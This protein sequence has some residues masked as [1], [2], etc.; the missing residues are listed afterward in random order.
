MLF[1]I[2]VGLMVILV[3]AFWVYQGL[4]SSAL[5]FFLTIL[6]SA[7][8]FAFYE[9]VSGLVAGFLDPS[10][11]LPLA[12]LVLF[13]VTLVL[14]RL[15]TDKFIPDNV[16]LP[17]VVDRAGAGL[18]GL[19]TGLMIVGT[20]LIGVQMFGIGSAVFGFERLEAGD[21]G[22][23]VR[24]GFLLGPDSFAAGMMQT[25]SGG[26]LG[27]GNP[28]GTAKPD[29]ILDLYAARASVQPEDRVIIPNDAVKVTAWWNAQQIDTV[30]HRAQ[31]SELVR[32]F[33]T[34]DAANGK[35]IVCT[36]RVS[37][38]AANAGKQEIYFR[39]PQFRLV[40]P[41][42]QKGGRAPS[43]VTA[44]GMSDIY[45][46]TQY[47]NVKE[48]SPE[49]AA[50]LVRF[51]P[52]TPFVLDGN[53]TKGV[54]KNG[55]Y[56]FQV[57][58][59]VPENFNPWYLEFKRG[60]R[61][62]LTLAQFRDKPPASASRAFG[63]APA[64][65]AAAGGD[66]PSA[67]SGGAKKPR[68]GPA[69]A[70]RT[71]IANAIQERT[72]PSAKLPFPLDSSNSIVDK[73]LR[74][75][76]LDECHFFVALPDTKE[77]AKTDVKEFFVPE[78]KKLFQVGAEA[79]APGSLLGRAVNYAANVAGQVSIRDDQGSDYLAVGVYS[80]ARVDGQ[81]MLE[82]Q[83]HPEAEV[84]ERC[85]Q[86]PKKITPSILTSAPQKERKFGYL[87]LVPPGVRIVRFTA[88]KTDS[89]QHLDITVP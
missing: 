56:E 81:M 89:I 36:V 44:C 80:V 33:A 82:I 69:P 20:S 18:F 84:P 53:I 49:Q 22:Q 38:S 54:F 77:G 1:S 2:A 50:R 88:G 45:T 41:P 4:F 7:V 59:D 60:A 40:G 31:G 65:A 15:A 86:K 24:K 14:L 67:S 19:L 66:A 5:F 11:G 8:A 61:A 87:F 78:G 6:S 13:V 74:G 9:P 55:G 26:S 62:E 10:L 85:L 30:T 32:E 21:T 42:P 75:K 64:L 16:R 52:Q 29:L 47:G 72:G 17:V 48:V 39:L 79:V 51:S 3:G 23:P 37:P 46:H 58:F 71:Q 25:L 27:G 70:G 83:Y 43:L 73:C 68:V 34:Q 12:F 57:A 28:L 35:F 76:R 63:G